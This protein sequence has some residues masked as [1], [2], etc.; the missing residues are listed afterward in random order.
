[1]TKHALNAFLATSVAFINEIARVA[2]LVGADAREVER[3]LKSDVRIGPRAY[4]K[5]GG[6]YAGGTLARDIAYLIERGAALG[7]PM[8][9]VRG[10]R[11]SNDAHRDWACT[12]P[13]RACWGRSP[14]RLSRCW[15]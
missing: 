3:G 11:A 4:V 14:A 7:C 13:S 5:P 2:E 8:H 1:M 10:V 12:T 6:A 15:G 9:L